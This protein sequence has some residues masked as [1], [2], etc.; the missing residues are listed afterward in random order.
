MKIL[1]TGSSGFVG[2]ALTAHLRKCGYTVIGAVRH[3]PRPEEVM[4]G[5]IKE[6][7][8]W[9][10]ALNGCD[11]VIHTAALIH[12]TNNR[13]ENPLT[14]LRQVNLSGTLQ[15][16]HQARAAGIKRLIF[17]STAKVYGEEGERPY[18]ETDTP[19]PKDA[20]AISKWEAE[21]K[22]SALSQ[23]D[24]MEVVIIRPPLVYGPGVKGNFKSLMDW[25]RKGL[26]LPL[27]A[28]DNRRSLIALDNLVD[29]IT[30]CADR[31]KSPRAAN[32]IF[33]ISDGVDVSTPE[34]LRRVAHAYD[35]RAHLISVP[36]RWLRLAFKLTGKSAAAD[37]LLGSLSLDITKAHVMLGWQPSVT[38]DEQLLKMAGNVTSS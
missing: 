16:A 13:D 8:D 11:A 22:L 38:I 3:N 25:V 26:P 29:F 18:I 28:I 1:V 7:T 6:D 27:G 20:Y 2:Q 35:T 21:Q 4:V 12:Q 10:F 17:I 5:E 36:E 34:L 23:E 19:S 15:L 24:G 37:R 32:E 33:L 14:Q 30:L 9:S 31:E